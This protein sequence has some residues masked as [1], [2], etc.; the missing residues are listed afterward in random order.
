MATD[1]NALR[2]AR[3]V[4]YSNS[5]KR[6]RF[7]VDVA[8]GE[9]PPPSEIP[10]YVVEHHYLHSMALITYLRHLPRWG[11]KRSKRFLDTLVALLSDEGRD[12]LAPR[13]TKT[14]STARRRPTF[15]WLVDSRAQGRRVLAWLS[16][17]QPRETPW[18]GWPLSPPPPRGD[19]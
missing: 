3:S 5:M 11:D 4:R 19:E 7:L 15:G 9:A 13:A 16:L 18:V 1:D 12:P 10:W 6:A 17:T 14:R 2:H 8:N